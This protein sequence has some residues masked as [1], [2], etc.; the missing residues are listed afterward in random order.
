MWEIIMTI[1]DV[2]DEIDNTQ[3]CIVIK[4]TDK[5]ECDL[6]YIL[7]ND[8]H[9]YFQNYSEIILFSNSNYPVKIV[10]YDNFKKANPIIIGEYIENDITNDWF[11]IAIGNNSQYITIDLAKDRLGR[12]YDS[13]WDRHGVAGDNPVIAFS[14]TEL[15]SKLLKAKG[16]YYYWLENNFEYLGDAYD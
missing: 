4:K 7:P 15:L 16:V 5:V 2:I 14:F 6:D 12:C 9:Y 3:D 11:I 8:L 13:F 1:K 10:G